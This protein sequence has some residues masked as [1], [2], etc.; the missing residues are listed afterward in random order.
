MSNTAPTEAAE[1]AAQLS[2]AEYLLDDDPRVS[3]DRAILLLA[4]ID[5]WHPDA[6]A[7]GLARV[8][9]IERARRA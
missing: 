8:A 1:T 5:T 3:L 7:A 4:C 6:V 2:V 9:Q